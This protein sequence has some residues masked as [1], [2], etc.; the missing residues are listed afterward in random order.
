VPERNGSRGFKGTMGGLASWVGGASPGKASL[1]AIVNPGR[2]EGS[3]EDNEVSTGFE[4]IMDEDC[5]ELESSGEVRLDAAEKVEGSGEEHVSQHSKACA[6]G[7]AGAE[8]GIVRVG[9][10]P[11]PENGSGG[12][13]TMAEEGEETMAQED[14]QAT[15]EEGEWVKCDSCYKWRLV[16]QEVHAQISQADGTVRLSQSAID[17]RLGRCLSGDRKLLFGQFHWWLLPHRTV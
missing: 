2:Y 17:V 10:P 9:E 5:I 3:G 13:Q 14:E 7:Q 8:A 6:G 11:L 1:D 15:T 16:S 12:E 4:G